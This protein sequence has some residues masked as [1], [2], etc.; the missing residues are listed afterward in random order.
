MEKCNRKRKIMAERAAGRVRARNGSGCCVRRA[1]KRMRGQ[2]A[3]HQVLFSFLSPQVA[4][5]FTPK[6]PRSSL[7]DGF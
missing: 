6:L 5:V 4:V 1:G 2:F 7:G 3:Q